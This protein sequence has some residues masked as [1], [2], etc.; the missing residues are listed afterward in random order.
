MLL[1]PAAAPAASTLSLSVKP[2][3]P[4]KGKPFTLTAAGVRDSPGW[5][6][7][8]AV[9]LAPGSSPCA[10][11]DDL[12][13]AKPINSVFP[14]VEQRFEPSGP[15]P[16]EVTG[17]YKWALEDPFGFKSGVVAGRYRACGYLS[18]SGGGEPPIA[19]V[20]RL[21]FTVG[22]TC[23]SAAA[24][25]AKAQRSLRTANKSVKKAKSALKKAKRGGNGKKVQ[26]AK[27]ALK[28]AKKQLSKAKRKLKIAKDDRAALC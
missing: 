15:E 7:D 6:Q 26:K 21:E 16:F 28:A 2:A 24:K 27:K 10:A 18:V 1:L 5:G 12:E 11:T 20:A 14:I 13:R 23:A 9:Y 8:L 25:Q 4:P 3:V 22:G 19:P 17:T